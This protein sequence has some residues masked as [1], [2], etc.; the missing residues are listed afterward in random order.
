MTRSLIFSSEEALRVALTSGLVPQQVQVGGAAVEVREDGSVRVAPKV[1]FPW[2][3]LDTLKSSGVKV[4]ASSPAP[5]RQVRCWAEIVASRRVGDF[6]LPSRAQVL[7]TVPPG[8]A[9]LDLAAELLRLGCDR[10]EIALAPTP[11]LAG[12]VRAADPPYY[13]VASALDTRS[14]IRAFLPTPAGQSLVWTEVGY[15]HPL[16]DSVKPPPGQLLFVNGGEEW[17]SSPDGPWT[18]VYKLID[19]QLPGEGVK[20]APARLGKR[21]TVTLRLARG[22]RD[23]APNLWV[24]RHDALAAVDSLVQTLPEDVI[25]RLLFAAA[26]TPENPIVILRA[27]AAQK[28]PPE[29]PIKAEPYLP[30]MQIGNL[31]APADAV[32]EPPL[33]RE[34]VRELLAPDPELITWL[35]PVEGTRAFRVEGIPEAALAPLSD[36][37]DYLVHSRAA[38]LEPWVRSAVFEFAPFESVGGEWG[39]KRDGG[40]DD[41]E[42]RGKKKRGSKTTGGG[43]TSQVTRTAEEEAPAPEKRAKPAEAPRPAVVDQAPSKNEQ[44]LTELQRAFLDL[45]A[46]ADDP[47]RT[48]M[49]LQMAQLHS[50]LNQGRDAGLCY[51]RSL[52]ELALE[53]GRGVLDSWTRA[54]AGD[55]KLLAV[56]VPTRDQVRMLAVHLVGRLASG[57][58]LSPTELHETQVWLDKH[59]DQLDVRSLWLARWALSQLVGGD[60]LSLARARDRILAKLH[61]GL[62]LERDVPSFL[63]F[64]GRHGGGVDASATTR[65]VAKLTALHER[66]EKTERK[67]DVLEANPQL[68]RAYVLYLFAYGFARLGQPD[69]ARKLRDQATKLIL[70][71]PPPE[72][73]KDPIHAYLMSAYSARIDQALEGIPP[74]TPLPSAITSRLNDLDRLNQFKVNRLRE[75]SS[76]LESQQRFDS[77]DAF[78][79]E[80]VDPRGEEFAS[81]RAMTDM[82]QLDQAVDALMRKALKEKPEEKARLFDGLMDFFPILPEGQVFPRVQGILGSLADVAPVKRAQILEEALVTAG[83]FGRQDLVR[84]I[85]GTLKKTVASLGTE[86]IMEVGK[87]LAR[88]LRTLRRVGL[89]DEAADLLTAMQSKVSGKGAEMLIARLQLAG[90]LAYL[91]MRDQA[92]PTFDEGRAQFK[93]K[94]LLPKSRLAIV[95]A[96]ALA[97]SH[98]PQEYATAEIFKIVD[99]LPDITDKFNTNTHFCLSVINFMESLILGL[100]S[101]DLAMGE[102]GRRWIE[103]DEY[104]VRRRVHR[105]L[106]ETA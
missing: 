23:Q 44:V 6:E 54:E 78:T 26:G 1:A 40:D 10:Q 17:S 42:E 48:E 80:L 86:E 92:E 58:K 8:G 31:Y 84:E 20:L 29:L 33:R 94:S 13:T 100:A 63:R 85:L 87:I 7:F 65:L 14:G 55:L 93:D 30:L 51:G 28:A 4:D 75:G 19:L 82:V 27:R 15:A 105:D 9:P 34:R 99:V 62:S 16:V 88:T 39:V 22:A 64:T 77:F 79:E 53:E 104:L 57:K 35:A 41:D 50:V 60:R 66:F 73:K 12:L 49:W 90:G 74:E 45:D 98:T 52:W 81:M 21:L 5:E 2:A 38:Q 56:T 36:W 106:G 95:R 71:Q 102:L 24:V 91:G 11:G 69:R 76:I 32:L 96:L 70:D 3:A 68:T 46:P 59:D 61:R 72:I 97:L 37:V 25:A 83:F 47:R 18:D 103:E 101:E 67:R 43:K 89:R